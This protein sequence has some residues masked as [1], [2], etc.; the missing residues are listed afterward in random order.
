MNVCSGRVLG[1]VAGM[2][3]IAVSGCSVNPPE[4]SQAAVPSEQVAPTSTPEATPTPIAQTNVPTPE[5]A[6]EVP[7]DPVAEGVNA[8]K[9]SDYQKA[10]TLL[11]PKAIEGDAEAQV[12]VGLLFLYNN[13]VVTRNIQTAEM[14]IE[15]SAEQGNLMGLHY[16]G[17][18]HDNCNDPFCD[19]AVAIQ[20]YQKAAERGYIP[21]QVALARMYSRKPFEDSASERIMYWFGKAAESGSLEAKIA[22]AEI[23]YEGQLV[24][25]DYGKALAYLKE[26]VD[27]GNTKAIDEDT[28]QAKYLLAMMYAKGLGVA[29]DE[30]RA[31]AWFREAVQE[32]EQA[33]Y[34]GKSRYYNV[35]E[36]SKEAM[37]K[38]GTGTL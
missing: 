23:Y 38:L 9:E 24:S 2:L 10:Y 4:S 25:A 7:Q 8:L 15:K 27:Q 21:S 37:E 20:N 31:F 35:V 11:L 12:Y 32:G 29:K 22:L 19:E 28:S 18:I 36:R 34:G 17:F 33:S 1:I 6:N 3:A 30:T 16:A 14:W 26:V 13:D 5:E